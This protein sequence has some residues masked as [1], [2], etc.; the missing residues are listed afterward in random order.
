MEWA[1]WRPI[2]HE[3][4]DDLGFDI[5]ADVKSA[6]ILS[7]LVL[8]KRIPDY[9]TI[10]EKLGQRVSIAGPAESLEDDIGTLSGG[11]TLISAGGDGSIDE[12]GSG[13]RHIGHRSRR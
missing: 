13:P 9:G 1:E 7:K 2:Y 6:E 11:E 12:V 8:T 4:M 5:Q 10:V 3:L